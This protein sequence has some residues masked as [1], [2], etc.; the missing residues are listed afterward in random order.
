L[1]LEQFE[2]ENERYQIKVCCISISKCNSFLK[3]E[4]VR[5][6]KEEKKLKDNIKSI[7]KYNETKHHQLAAFSS[8]PPCWGIGQ[9]I[10]S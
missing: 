7:K 2:N 8:S 1:F 5:K 6:E 3:S 10:A 9:S 4:E